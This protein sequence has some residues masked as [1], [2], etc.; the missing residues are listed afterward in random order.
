MPPTRPPLTR[1]RCFY[2]N[3]PIGGVAGLI[4]LLF[5]HTP[6]AAQPLAAPLRE[7]LLQMDLPG[8][9][10]LMGA[11]I[12]FILALQYGGQTHPWAS[13]LP[14]G[15]LVGFVL[16]LAAFTAVEVVQ[17]ER[18]MLAPRLMRDRNVWVSGVFACVFAGA[19]FVVIYYLP[20]YFQSI[21]G[22]SPIASGVRNLPLILAVTVATVVSGASISRTGVATPLMV[23]GAVLATVAAGLL[24]TLDVGTGSGPWIGYQVLGGL[25][26]GVAFQVPM[27][28]GQGTA[29][30][31]DLASVTAIILCELSFFFFSFSSFPPFFF[32]SILSPA[33]PSTSHH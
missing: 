21:D 33:P 4:I 24:Y 2:I 6:T 10:L 30:P 17:G 1:P 32:H 18:A 11:V 26:W 19:Y 13:S 22:A 7:K 15:L 28:I 12:S 31:S 8:T 27:I 23:V 3:L 5:F 14:V 20:L 9:T 29:A 16:L 25:G